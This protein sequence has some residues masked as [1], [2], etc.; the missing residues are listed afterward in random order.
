MSVAAIDTH[1]HIYDPARPGGVPWPPKSE[2]VLY[3]R[4][5]AS[6][7][8]EA[9]RG[10]NVAGAVIVE[11]SPWLADNDWILARAKEDSAFVCVV[12]H[13]E[14]GAVSFAPELERLARNPKFRG[15]RIGGAKAVPASVPDLRKL[16]AVGL[17]LDVLGNAGQLNGVATLA[18][19]IP[20]LRIIVNHLPLYPTPP[21]V[22]QE[23]AAQPNVWIK[24]SAVVRRDASGAVSEELEPYR[25]ALDELWGLFGE[26]RLVYGS[27]WPVSNRLS[28]Y[29]AQIGVVRTYFSGKG[30]KA[31]EA[32][33]RGNAKDVYRWPT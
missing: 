17:S 3:R 21:N 11:A 8:H 28:T 24:V 18:A 10:S 12:G 23:L 15:I 27:N 9:V 4:H 32:F 31:E 2:P 22:L 29:S 26:K 7:F 13:L 16:A 5:T 20:T 1:I 33:F 19:A 14:P 6:E 30:P 25:D